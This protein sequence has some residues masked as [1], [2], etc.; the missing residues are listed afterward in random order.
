MTVYLKFLMLI[1][2]KKLAVIILV[3]H[4]YATLNIEAIA[5][6]NEPFILKATDEDGYS[7]QI[8]SDFIVGNSSK[9]RYG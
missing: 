9:T 7:A 2:C 5:K 6:L 8:T 1:S 4:Q 3:L